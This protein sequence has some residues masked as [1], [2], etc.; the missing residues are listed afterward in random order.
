MKS[1]TTKIQKI[2]KF[3]VLSNNIIIHTVP[4]V[5]RSIY[6]YY[7]IHVTQILNKT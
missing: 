1:V 5:E 4:P 2:N 3:I 6:Y 7:I